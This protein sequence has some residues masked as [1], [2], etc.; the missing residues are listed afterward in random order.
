MSKNRFYTLLAILATILPLTFVIGAGYNIYD[1]LQTGDIY[2]PQ[3]VLLG[4]TQVSM[5]CN[6]SVVVL[7]VIA[8]IFVTREDEE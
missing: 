7:L 4:F 8:C 1:H 5:V 2:V 6:A 3:Q